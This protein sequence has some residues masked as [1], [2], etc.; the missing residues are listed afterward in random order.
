[1][2]LV[3]VSHLRW[4]FV[5]QR[6]QHLMS[7]A[8]RHH[9]VLFVEEP[10][11]GD[12]FGL[13]RRDVLPSLSVVVPRIPSDTDVAVAEA[14]LTDALGRL[15]EGWRRPASTLVAWHWNVMAEA[16]TRGWNADV[17]VFDC[18]DEL[19]LFHG[20]PSQLVD[21]E[22]QLMGRADVVFTGGYSLWE[23]KR[24]HHP[25]VH[26]FPSSVDLDHFRTARVEQ[27]EPDVLRGIRRP[28]LL[29]AGVIDER[30]DLRLL[31]QLAAAD[32]GEVVLVGPVAKIDERDVPS[33]P[34]IHRLGMQPYA[35]LPSLFAHADVGIMPFA[36]NDATRYISPTKTPEYLAAGL[37]VVST[38]I[39]DVVR[40]YGD[41]AGA[42]Y[43][44]DD[45]R[46]F[47]E[48]CEDAVAH[49]PP[50]DMVDR[51]LAGMSWDAT[52]AGMERLI[53]RHGSA[54]EVV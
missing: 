49:R 11:D 12:A 30:I 25:S 31:D 10:A 13:D 17:V 34:R 2:D 27:P 45:H 32:V 36:R 18:M 7:R 9:R 24:D 48:A 33:A 8:A 1:M 47:L 4:D 52:W 44:A 50:T 14:W 37:P 42:V 51:R 53:L 15:V 23:A 35:D 39:R 3:A 21:R 5:Y 26:P 41:L 38:P 29:Y 19:S 22:R 43:V 40:G 20:A 16:L 46:A 28:R 6:P 54:A